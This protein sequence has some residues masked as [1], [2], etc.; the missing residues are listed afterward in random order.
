[1]KTRLFVVLGALAVVAIFYIAWHKNVREAHTLVYSNAEYGFS[2][3]YPDS[4]VLQE[5][6]AGNG[7]RRH[8]SITLMDKEALANVPSAGEGPPSVSIDVF[9]NLERSSVISWIRG[10]NESNFKLSHSGTIATTTI[11]D[12]LAFQYEW[13]GLYR[14]E[15]VATARG[16]AIIVISG[17][18]LNLDDAIRSHY[19]SIL[20]SF[21][22]AGGNSSTATQ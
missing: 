7:E 1:M 16:N 21:R 14:G 15:S 20:Q 3:Q 8:T 2:F 13:D 11:A 17:T 18:Y 12:Q 10:S 9:Q 4:L 19:A 22:F 5:R 6:E